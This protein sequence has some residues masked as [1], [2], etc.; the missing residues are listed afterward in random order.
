MDRSQRV[1][2][3]IGSSFNN[4]LPFTLANGQVIQTTLGDI[5]SWNSQNFM[6]GPRS[7]NE[8]LSMFKYFRFTERIRF[9]LNGDFFN[10]FNHPNNLNPN[11]TTGL[12][13]LSQQANDPRII[14]L[15]ARLEW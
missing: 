9:R 2:R 3:P 13:D 10:L 11:K 8:D 15:G 7:W 12:I 14:Q 5:Q 6:L 1:L 4:K